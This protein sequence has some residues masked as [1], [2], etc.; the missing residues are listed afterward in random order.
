MGKEY[1]VSPKKTPLLSERDNS[2]NPNNGLNNGKSKNS[3]NKVW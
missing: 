1:M 2:L 3:P